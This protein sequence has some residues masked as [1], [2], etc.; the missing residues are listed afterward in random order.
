MKKEG[1]TYVLSTTKDEEANLDKSTI[2]VPNPYS[3]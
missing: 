3:T 1:E 2:T